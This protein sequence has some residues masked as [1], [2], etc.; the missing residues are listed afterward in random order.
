MQH[1][2]FKQVDKLVSSSTQISGETVE[3]QA[4]SRQCVW[5]LNSLGTAMA[6]QPEN[7]LVTG[8]QTHRTFDHHGPKANLATQLATV[9]TVGL[10]LHWSIQSNFTHGLRR[11]NADKRRAVEMLLADEEWSAKSDRWIAETA[12]VHHSTVQA[13]KQ[14]AESATSPVSGG[15]SPEFKMG[16]DG[17][18]YPAKKATQPR[19][20]AGPDL[21]SL[22]DDQ[23]RRLSL[24]RQGYSQLANKHTD[25][26]LI[27]A[28]QDEGI[29]CRI[30][31]NSI[32]G[33]PFILD[34]DGDRETVIENYADYLTKRPSLRKMS[35]TLRGRILGCWCYPE[36]CHGHILMKEFD[37]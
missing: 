36:P 9:E 6:V 28:A 7:R 34:E 24:A 11:S 22:T 20:T 37:I 15:E 18:K 8:W 27:K 17:K 21:T 25:S 19:R 10:Q 13:I 3:P 16:A 1:A 23:T 12:G 31:R 33:N 2:T 4:W 29:Y 30:D 14:V 32:W 5:L 26:A 35:A